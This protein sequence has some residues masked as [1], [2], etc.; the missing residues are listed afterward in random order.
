MK[1]V[2]A[3]CDHRPLVARD[4]QPLAD[5]LTALRNRAWVIKFNR[6]FRL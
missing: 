5:E 1:V 4:D 2:F 3:T 6:L